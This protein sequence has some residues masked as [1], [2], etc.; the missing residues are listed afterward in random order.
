MKITK[1]EA[2]WLHVPIP[3]E[4]QH[5]TDFGRIASFDTTLVRIETDTGITGH[6]EARGAL[7]SSSLNHAINAV[8]N[9]ELGPALVG[10]D[11][12]RITRLWRTQR[13]PVEGPVFRNSVVCRHLVSLT[14]PGYPYSV[15]KA[16]QCQLH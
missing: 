12:R 1:V 15:R 13:P 10:K 3:Q 11:P 6:G 9:R 2:I 5:V 14:L 8:V 16:E 7:S 4:R